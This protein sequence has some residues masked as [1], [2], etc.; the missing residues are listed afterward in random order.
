MLSAFVLILT[1]A[2]AAQ[3][4]A[5]GAFLPAV[6]TCFT[7]LSMTA[8]RV[9]GSGRIRLTMEA[10]AADAFLPGL[11]SFVGMAA[12]RAGP[13]GKRKGV[14]AMSEGGTLPLPAL[15]AAQM[16]RVDE[17]MTGKLGVDTL[18]LMELAGGAV[19]S[20]ARN[21]FLGG[22]TRGKRVIAFCGSGGNGGDALVAARLLVA[23]GANVAVHLS[24][25]SGDLHGAAA[26]QAE[27]LVKMGITPNPP[28]NDAPDVSHADVLLDGLLGF[29]LRGAPRGMT[30]TLIEAANAAGPPIL[31][32][33]VPSGLDATTGAMT[34]ACIRAAA[35]LT[36]A[37]PKAGLG[38]PAAR[39]FTG[40][41]TV[42]DIGVP[43]AVYN[44][45][46][47]VLAGPPFASSSF[48]PWP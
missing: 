43:P 4:T 24:H 42:A 45:L 6:R 37:L 21:R 12:R 2:L 40:D 13:K 23:W 8:S 39:G 11:A 22:D 5:A 19:A 46:G 10:A 31:A 30:R 41:I 25:E 20:F 9:G 47:I 14:Y 29:S 38:V 7:S 36:L 35:T 48:V 32:I 3:T 26:H 28:G 16:A 33:D 1:C 15:S 34:G 18:Q 27:I 17:L 44:R